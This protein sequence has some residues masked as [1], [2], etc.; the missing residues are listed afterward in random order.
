MIRTNIRCKFICRFFADRHNIKKYSQLMKSA[1]K[2][3]KKH[4]FLLIELCISL[5]LFSLIMVTLFSSY[6]ELCMIQSSLQQQK[7]KIFS[8]Q[9]L[10]L[11]LKQIFKNLSSF[12]K[13]EENCWT[14]NYD[15]ELEYDPEL[16]GKVK[17]MFYLSPF[18]NCEDPLKKNLIYEISTKDGKSRLEILFENVEDCTFLFF[19]E[20]IKEWTTIYPKISPRF[21]KI[22]MNKNQLIVPLF[23]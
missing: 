11:R 17:A 5:L 4:A 7:S 22:S 9:K 18:Y 6:R 15:N 3:P 14:F 13:I 12:E 10:R 16:R 8:Q 2:S 23:L 21:I 1:M 20:S 19:D